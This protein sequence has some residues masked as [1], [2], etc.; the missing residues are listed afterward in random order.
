MEAV[1]HSPH[2]QAAPSRAVS[3][4]SSGGSYRLLLQYSCNVPNPLPRALLTPGDQ[5]TSR[6]DP[7]TA[8]PPPRHSIPGSEQQVL[9]WRALLCSALLQP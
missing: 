9:R 2:P 3:V 5:G 7:A 8:A 6:M 4:G 1:P